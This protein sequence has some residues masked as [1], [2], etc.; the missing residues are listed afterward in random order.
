[1]GRCNVGRR[2]ANETYG[3]GEHAVYSFSIVIAE[4]NPFSTRLNSWMLSLLKRPPA[5]ATVALGIVET[6]T[7]PALHINKTAFHIQQAIPSWYSC[8]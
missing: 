7:F 8:E 1:M 3:K 5:C 6:K 4:R 2:L